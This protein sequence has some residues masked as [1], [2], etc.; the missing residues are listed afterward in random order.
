VGVNFAWAVT[1][2][3]AYESVT[4]IK[5][6]GQSPP[7]FFSF[8]TDGNFTYGLNLVFH[9]DKPEKPIR[10]I[11]AY[12]WMLMRDY[13]NKWHGDLGTRLSFDLQANLP[14][15]INKGKWGLYVGAA[16]RTHD[17]TYEFNNNGVSDSQNFK[18]SLSSLRLGVNW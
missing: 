9:N 7:N 6:K 13:N 11:C 4:H 5:V 10:L 2:L 16:Y 3:E 15:K 17:I 14:W 8:N 1:S 18:S 12:D